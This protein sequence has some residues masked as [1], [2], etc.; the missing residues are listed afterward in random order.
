M[1]GRAEPALIENLSLK[2][3]LLQPD[4][5]SGLKLSCPDGDGLANL[6]TLVHSNLCAARL[7]VEGGSIKTPLSFL[8]CFDDPEEVHISISKHRQQRCL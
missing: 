3:L 1:P 2:S 4:D 7:L 8:I 6:R 5:L